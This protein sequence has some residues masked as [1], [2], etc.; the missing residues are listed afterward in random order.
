MVDPID[1][2]V[3]Q[4]LNKYDSKY[5][6]TNLGKEGIKLSAAEDDEISKQEEETEPLRKYLVDTFPDRLSKV[7]VST[8]LVS[9]PCALVAESW[10]YTATM[11]RVIQSQALGDKRAEKMWVGK[12]VMEI[13]PSHPLI[14]KL[15]ELVVENKESP[16]AQKIASLLIDTAAITSGY[17]V[18]EP[19]SFAKNVAEMLMAGMGIEYVAPDITEEPVE[20][21]FGTAK[22]VAEEEKVEKPKK[23]KSYHEDDHDEL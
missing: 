21:E 11:E 3:M 6:L 8:R 12:K 7:K 13:N 5:K 19:A 1:E 18:K 22:N 20:E 23:K 14:K 4:H 10:G 16:E 15:G 17:Q 2:Y 9:S